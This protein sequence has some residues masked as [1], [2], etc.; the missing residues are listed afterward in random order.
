MFNAANT[1]VQPPVFHP[2]ASMA[3][4]FNS[5]VQLWEDRQSCVETYRVYSRAFKA[6]YRRYPEWAKGGPRMIDHAGNLVGDETGYPLD[7]S[8]KP[9]ERPGHCRVARPS[10]H[11]VKSDFEV[12]C[13]TILGGPSSHNYE[14]CRAKARARMRERMRPIIARL[15]E[16]RRISEDLGLNR[17]EHELIALVDKIGGV[18]RQIVMLHDSADRTAALIM[19]QVE[20]E[21][22]VGDYADGPGYC[23]TMAMAHLAL[24]SL[25]PQLSAVIHEHADFFVSNPTLAACRMP[26]WTGCPDDATD[27]PIYA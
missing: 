8:V 26:F 10:P 19:A 3:A 23:G 14:A 16:R 18:E 25:L 22:M 11:D 1:H 7:T 12:Y 6:A 27:E 20:A 24:R 13:R 15:R 2:T 21:C 17:I 5:A 9:P 4:S